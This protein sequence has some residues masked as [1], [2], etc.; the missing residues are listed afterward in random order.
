LFS[1]SF[2][3]YRVARLPGQAGRCDLGLAHSFRLRRE[4]MPPTC[5]KIIS[6]TTVQLKPIR[7]N[8]HN[9]QLQYLFFGNLGGLCNNGNP[10]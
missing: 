4:A 1:G 5:Q 9:P 8:R 6:H 2:A 10:K 3:E 7:E